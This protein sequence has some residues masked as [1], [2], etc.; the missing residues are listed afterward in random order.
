M[1][2]SEGLGLEIRFSGGFGGISLCTG[3]LGHPHNTVAGFLQNMM[4]GMG[5]RDAGGSSLFYELALEITCHHFYYILF[6]RREVHIWHTVKGK[7]IRL[8]LLKEK[9]SKTATYLK[10]PMVSKKLLAILNIY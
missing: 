2:S 10:M 7:R 3:L 6:I 9:V 8:H 5:R 1:Q 4:E